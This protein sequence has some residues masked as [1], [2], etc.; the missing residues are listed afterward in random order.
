MQERVIQPEILDQLA[1]SHPDA[2]RSRSDL[3]KLDVFLGNSRWITRTMRE[4]TKSG[5][6]IRVVELGAGE[7]WLCNRL[8]KTIPHL[9]VTGLD[10]AS[11]PPHLAS[12]VKWI[13]GDFLKTLAEIQGDVVVGSLILHHFSNQDLERFSETL[14]KFKLLVFSEPYRSPFPLALANFALPFFG[15]VTRHD[16]PA[17]IKAGFRKGELAR[18][19]R[20]DPKRWRL[21]EY[22]HYGNSLRT[23]ASQA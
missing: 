20:L 21:V 8:A 16:M 12:G 18:F 9:D 17:S 2:I 7:G 14:K 3:R 19:L 13:R 5:M 1:P 6:A 10:F 23:V 22:S 4:H 11:A 15:K